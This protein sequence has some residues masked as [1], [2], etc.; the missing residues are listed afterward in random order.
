M[1]FDLAIR[2]TEILLAIAFVIQSLEHL[3]NAKDERIL[4]VPRIVFSIMLLL[5]FAVKWICLLLLINSLFILNR[6]RGPYNGGSDRMGLLIL[7]S[8]C[9]IYFVP[10]L[11]WQQ[12]IFAYL[13]LQVVLS[14]FLSGVFKVI[15]P[16]WWNGKVL[17]DIFEFSVFPANES[18]R[19]LAS[20]PKLLVLA[21]WSVLLFELFFPLALFTTASLVIAIGLAMV[22]HLANTYIFGFNRFFWV[23]LAAYPSLIWFQNYIAYR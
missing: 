2:L 14:Y 13:A 8:L 6:F 19:D 21:S 23:W 3:S 22:F 16:E 1:S 17:K 15:N 20:K 9:L 4:F 5:G 12:Y 11:L 7:A 10:N 18:L